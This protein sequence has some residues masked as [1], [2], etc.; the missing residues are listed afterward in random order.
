MHKY[1]GGGI[2]KT[3]EPN[4]LKGYSMPYEVQCKNRVDHF[5][6]TGDWLGVGSTSGKELHCASLF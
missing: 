3:A 5:L 4:W 1:L 6:R 2:V